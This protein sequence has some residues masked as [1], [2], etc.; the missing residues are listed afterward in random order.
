MC[1]DGGGGRTIGI[2]VNLEIEKNGMVN[3]HHAIIAYDC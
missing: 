1:V 3:S 2:E